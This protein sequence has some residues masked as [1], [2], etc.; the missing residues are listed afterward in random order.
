ML[1][2]SNINNTNSNIF[3]EFPKYE[4]KTSSNIAAVNMNKKEPMAYDLVTLK[5][6]QNNKKKILFGSTLASSIFT[7]GVF[8]LIFLKGGHGSSFKKLSKISEN[9]AEKILESSNKQTKNITHKAAYNGRKAAKKG[10]DGLQ[11]VSNFTAIKDM[12]ADKIFK[13]N[14]VTR[15]F[16]DK[17]TESFKKVVDNAL[18]SK[19]DK[20]GIKV[21]NLT[22]SLNQFH[23]E[24][25]NNLD[26]AQKAQKIEIKGVTLTLGEW[27]EKLGYHSD[28]LVKTFDENFSMGARKSRDNKRMKLIENLPEQIRERFFKDNK[29][30][31]NSKNFATYATDDLTKEAQKELKKEIMSAKESITNNIPSVHEHIK[32]VVSDF[33]K[34]L[35]PDDAKSRETLS[36]LKT[37]I[38]NFKNCS[39]A[40]E[41]KERK[42]ISAKI[43]KIT[44]GLIK[45]LKESSL[46]N[47]A[48]KKSILKQI[49]EINSTVIKTNT[50]GS[51]GSLEEIMTILKG[52][53]DANITISDNEFKEFSKLSKAIS[54]DLN[55]AANLETG[56]YF[57]K[58]AEMKVGSAPTDVLSVLLPTGVGAYAVAKGDN[59]DERVSAALTTCIPLAGTFATFVYGTSKMFSGP[60]NLIFSLVSGALLNKAGTYCDKLYKNYKSTGSVSNTVKGEYDRI[61]NDMTSNYSEKNK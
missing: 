48:E 40:A 54:K 32:S 9:L 51:K 25:I 13:T 31:F 50:Q 42:E 8:G 12:I 26:A 38:E 5:K 60:K 20:V 28:N 18:G 3:S 45:N 16:A 4:L 57:L 6:R 37:E 53:N 41:A 61:K 47:E 34:S 7:A 11:A 43:T 10:I 19:Y 49:N 35:K 2:N 14:K 56:E 22:S 15:K 52:L 24:N 55:K 46:Y 27:A 1:Q 33:S 29:I 59:K 39:G 44:S 30:S 17:S 36:I 21:K 58:Q 23:L